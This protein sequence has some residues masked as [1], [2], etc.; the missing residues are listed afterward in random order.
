[1]TPQQIDPDRLLTSSEVGNL[2]QVNPS[3][4]NKWVEKGHLRAYRTPGGHR[5]IRISDLMSFLEEHAYPVPRSLSAA[6]RRR[7][8]VVDDDRDLLRSLTRS[9]RSHS[10]IDLET[11]D[12][13]IDALVRVGAWRPHLVVLDIFMPELDGIEVCRRLSASTHLPVRPLIVVTSGQLTPELERSALEAGARRA[14]AK[15]IALTALLADL[16]LDAQDQQ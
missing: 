14:L 1:M 15:P 11:C 4:I 2:L 3:S 12:N 6:A 5:R 7:V 13:G 10:H 16:A 9:A 8:L